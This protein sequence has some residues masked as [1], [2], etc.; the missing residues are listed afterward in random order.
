[1]VSL[2]LEHEIN[3]YTS[4]YTEK[5]NGIRV[6]MTIKGD[7]RWKDLPVVVLVN[8]GCVSSGDHLANGLAACPNVTLMGM[9][10]ACG[11]AQS[12]GGV[13][14][15]PDSKIEFHYPI[16]LDTTKDGKPYIDAKK[17]RKGSLVLDEVI[18]LNEKAIDE[19]FE[20]G[21]DYELQYAIDYISKK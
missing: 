11:S 7:G 6:P 8:E 2:F 16:Y 1:V 9:T 14:I 17:D 12:I 5:E 21:K 13:C 18:D 4:P 10:N 19:I 20:K 3:L 15:L